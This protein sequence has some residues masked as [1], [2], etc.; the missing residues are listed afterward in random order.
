MEATFEY[1]GEGTVNFYC[2]TKISA[3]KPVTLK[4]EVF[5][6]KAR[7]VCAE[8]ESLLSE[9]VEEAEAE[10]EENPEAEVEAE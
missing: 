8:P 5:I 10:V 9:V 4:D 6:K 1:S 3:G 2:G 7:A